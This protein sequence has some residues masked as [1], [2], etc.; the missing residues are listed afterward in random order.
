MF[1]HANL[2]LKRKV[3]AFFDN[4]GTEQ[5]YEAIEKDDDETE[6]IFQQSHSRNPTARSEFYN[7]LLHKTTRMGVDKET[8]EKRF[9]V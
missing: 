5:Y 2:V 7:C 3:K 6:A 9:C 8:V 1:Y 4:G